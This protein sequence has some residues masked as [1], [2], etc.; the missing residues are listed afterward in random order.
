MEDGE[1]RS[2]ERER[3]RTTT[4]W[5]HVKRSNGV[6]CK[7]CRMWRESNCEQPRRPWSPLLL[8]LL[9]TRGQ[10]NKT[11][12]ASLFMRTSP[13]N[14]GAYNCIAQAA[15]VSLPWKQW[16]PFITLFHAF[17]HLRPLYQNRSFFRR[18]IQCREKKKNDIGRSKFVKLHG[19]LCT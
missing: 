8:V 2:E 18:I 15:R 10:A 6:V 17:L 12:K 11:N 4:I 1:V 14:S 13:V 5:S 19:D 7:S 3:E 16:I 9:Y